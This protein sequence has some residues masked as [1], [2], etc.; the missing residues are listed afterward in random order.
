MHTYL[1]RYVEGGLDSIQ[2]EVS[3][4]TKLIYSR[5]AEGSL[6]CVVG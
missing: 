2:W 6:L 3:L 5:F 1:C 4:V